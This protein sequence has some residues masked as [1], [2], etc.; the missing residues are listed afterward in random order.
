VTERLRALLDSNVVIAA[1]AEDHEHHAS[2]LALFESAEAPKFA[3]A[4]HSYA[5]CFATLTRTSG[6]FAWSAGEAW[7]ALASVATVSDLVGLSPA[8]T[9]DTVRS[10]AEQGLVGPLL[11][12][13]LIGETAVLNGIET[14]IT[15]NVRHMQQL[16]SQVATLT[17]EQLLRDPG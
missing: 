16:F 5:E 10:F 12:D 2:S 3:I 15:W 13:R 7:A 11:Y 14:I 1:L 17:P 6:P 8:Q 4:A 9:F